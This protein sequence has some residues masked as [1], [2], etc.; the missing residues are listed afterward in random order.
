MFTSRAEFRLLLREDNAADRL[1]PIGRRLGLVDDERWRALRGVRA[2]G[3][4]AARERAAAPS[5]HRHAGG[6]RRAA[7]A[8]LGADRRTGAST[9]AELL[10]RPELDWRAVEAIAAAGRPRAAGASTP[11]V[12]ERVEIEIKYEG[13]LRAPGGRRARGWR[14]LDEV[15]AARRSRLRR[16]PR[17]VARGG[18]EARARSGR[19]RSARRRGSAA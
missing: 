8:R 17:P 10:R 15:R 18:R 16:H 5:R 6:Q 11:A 19:A 3:S 13:Y 2:P 14:A 1:L 4:P 7:R 12:A 9:L